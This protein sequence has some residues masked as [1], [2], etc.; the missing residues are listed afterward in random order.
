MILRR[1][2]DRRT[3]NPC[4]PEKFGLPSFGMNSLIRGKA[5]IYPIDPVILG[6]KRQK[7]LPFVFFSEK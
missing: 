6:K 5:R 4:H 2:Y 1:A 7:A 3:F